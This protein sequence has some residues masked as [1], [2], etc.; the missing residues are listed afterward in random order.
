VS[1]DSW[2]YLLQ[3]IICCHRRVF[4]LGFKRK[5]TFGSGGR[6]QRLVFG[7]LNR[8]SLVFFL[9]FLDILRTVNQQLF[10]RVHQVPVE[11]FLGVVP[12]GT[13]S[14]VIVEIF[15]HCTM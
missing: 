8:F 15:E 7:V 2:Q 5:F 10:V 3:S 12:A 4:G 11:L 14:L 9:Q 13:L 6:G 1:A